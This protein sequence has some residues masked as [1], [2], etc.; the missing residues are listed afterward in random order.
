M[1]W[2]TWR[3]FRPA[4]STAGAVLVA[5]APAQCGRQAGGYGG[6][7]CR[8]RLTSVLHRPTMA[9]APGG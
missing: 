7:L 2:L 9:L 4:A 1:I 6:G 3:Q 5:A 8:M